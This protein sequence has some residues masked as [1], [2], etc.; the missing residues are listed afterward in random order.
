MTT[1]HDGSGRPWPQLTPAQ[2][3][4]PLVLVV[5]LLLGA[6][7]V[8]T[9][10]G[11]PTGKADSGPGGTTGGTGT[12]P[13]EDGD[14]WSSAGDLATI[15]SEADEAGTLADYDWGDGCDPE[16]GRIELPTV[17]AP[18]CVP[19]WGGTK[20][21]VDRAGKAHADNGGA[22][23]RGV[24]ADE[25]VVAY[26]IPGPQDLLGLAESL[27]IFDD[28]S[29][30]SALLE[31]MAEMASDVYET[32]GRK[33]VIKPFQATGDGR[34]PA[35]ARADAR[36]VAEDLGA[37]ASIGGPTQALA[38][39]EE[40]AR[41][42]VLCISC[43]PSAPD[44]LYQELAPYVWSVLASP[45]QIIQGVLDFGVKNLSGK[46]AVHAGDPAYRTRERT[47]AVVHYDLDPPIFDSLTTR[48]KKR[49]KEM[50]VEAQ[51]I[52]SYLLDTN[53]LSAQAQGIIGRLKEEKIT[54]VVFACDPFMLMDLVTAASRQNYRPEWVIT[55]TVFTDT[56]AVGRL[57]SDQDQWSHA[58]GASSSPA[59]G[60]PN[61]SDAWRL[62]R[63]YQ[64]K[65]PEA[66]KSL[67]VTWPP[68]QLLFT[69][70]HMAGPNLTPETF[71]GGL[72]RYPPSGGG[73]TAP[74]I[75]YGDHGFFDQLD[76]V[77]I[78]DFTIVW[79]DP[80]LVGPSEQQVE[81]PGMWRYPMGGQRY[82][83]S[84][85][86]ELDDSLLFKDIPESPGILPEIPASDV[87]PDYPPPP[88]SPAA[89]GN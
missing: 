68:I 71:A 24:T 32:Y 39:Q 5:V 61:Q 10:K 26:Y 12:K 6:G 33:V 51:V 22:T 37:F 18:P 31:D 15:Y 29:A 69:G 11:G 21:W 64:G 42:G 47:M 78:D 49:Y 46:P 17:Y 23:H 62:Y 84:E 76:F 59:R 82:L 54:T 58:F 74:Q 45:D 38:Y 8:A 48:L 4:G 25:I 60:E 1:P 63:W 43:S 30:R 9:V 34:N 89:G 52:V 55:G 3:F 85:P 56:T 75:S 40:L 35:Q 77:G 41:R 80:K 27:G 87:A 67:Q 14:P 65:D 88:G 7:M 19:A 86:R 20:P 2:R 44:T 83:M 73:P 53:T 16:T 28:A 70:I 66:T 36:R 13:G 50:G 81:G 57:I 72:F 79:W